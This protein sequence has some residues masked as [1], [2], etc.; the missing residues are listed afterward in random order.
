MED[1]N[2]LFSNLNNNN[3]LLDIQ[4]YV[5]KVVS[6]RGFDDENEKDIMLL[7]L[8][9]VGEL[10]KAIRKHSGLKIDQNK[11]DSYGSISEE[12]ADVFI[13]LVDLSNTLNIDLFKAFKD[14]EEKNLKRSWERK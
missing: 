13:Y 6:I 10:A 3:S 12:I 8:E 1:Q 5:K 11:L 9:E 4:T 14:K 2:E 7:M